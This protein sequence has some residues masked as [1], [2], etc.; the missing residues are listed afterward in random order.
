MS[1]LKAFLIVLISVTLMLTACG[2][3]NQAESSSSSKETYNF[4]LTHI[5]QNTHIWQKFAEKFAEELTTKSD[6]RMKLEIYHRHCKLN[7]LVSFKT[8]R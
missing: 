7:S 3:E 8:E 2:V 4:K 5:T 6:G 1:K